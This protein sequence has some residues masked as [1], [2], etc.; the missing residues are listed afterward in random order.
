ML[1]PLIFDFSL[2]Q[3]DMCFCELVSLSF[4]TLIEMPL[5]K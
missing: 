3:N 4:V 5:E 1:F 2:F